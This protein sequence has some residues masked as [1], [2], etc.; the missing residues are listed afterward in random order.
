LIGVF[1]INK[2][3]IV[4]PSLLRSDGSY[5]KLSTEQLNNPAN[6]TR[7]N[8]IYSEKNV[9][10]MYRLSKQTR[11][12][13]QFTLG[14]NRQED[15]RRNMV[16][17]IMEK[18]YNFEDNNWLKDFINCK[19]KLEEIKISTNVYSESAFESKESDLSNSLSRSKLKQDSFSN[20]SSLILPSK[21]LDSK[22]S[23]K[24]LRKER[25]K[26]G[27][28][29]SVRFSEKQVEISIDTSQL[30][31]KPNDWSLNSLKTRP[32]THNLSQTKAGKTF[33][34]NQI[35][36]LGV[37]LDSNYYKNMNKRDNI[38]VTNST[39]CSIPLDNNSI[40]INS[41]KSDFKSNI[42][43]TSNSDK[44]NGYINNNNNN[45]DYFPCHS[46]KS[47]T[48]ILNSTNDRT[49]KQLETVCLNV[50]GLSDHFQ[51]VSLL[52][53]KLNQD[54]SDQMNVESKPNK[55]Q[56]QLEREVVFD[57]FLQENKSIRRALRQSGSTIGVLSKLRSL[58]VKAQYCREQK[59]KN[60]Q[61]DDRNIRYGNPKPKKNI[62]RQLKVLSQFETLVK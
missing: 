14:Q 36:N 16:T 3:M 45:C 20:Y 34:I 53:L 52:N 42:S 4:K 13:F 59:E 23:S 56:D 44:N 26:T 11:K 27:P 10:L 39:L 46:L 15:A 43:C 19:K 33:T 6:T 8:D 28:V 9:L 51:P 61:F 32:K 58:Q 48:S 17:S 55:P 22:H 29:D 60:F 31:D 57:N 30:V 54:P 37:T 35:D 21:N 40:L 62:S 50:Q 18:N 49:E 1:V 7:S 41:K 5:M 24:L 25:S 38:D 12:R 47:Y 2:K